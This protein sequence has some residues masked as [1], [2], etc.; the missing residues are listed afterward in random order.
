MGAASAWSAI[1]SRRIWL[2]LV[3]TWC[4]DDG[5]VRVLLRGWRGC[6]DV[7]VLWGS[8]PRARCRRAAASSY[9]GAELLRYVCWRFISGEGGAAA[10]GGLRVVLEGSG[11]LRPDRELCVLGAR[12]RPTIFRDFDPVRR[13]W[14][15][16]RSI[17]ALWL[18]VLPAPWVVADAGA[19]QLR[20]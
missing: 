19:V 14:W 9:D 4:T 10:E 15:L 11:L 20:R 18:G 17:S 8:L 7:L 6:D 16:L 3:G 1:L 13:G 12:R 5:S 2:L